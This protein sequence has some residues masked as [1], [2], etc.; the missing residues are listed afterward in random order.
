[1]RIR[2]LAVPVL[3]IWSIAL[4]VGFKQAWQYE[5]TPGASAN[6]P[7]NAKF[8]S[9]PQYRAGAP[10]LLVFAHPQCTCTRATIGNLDTLLAQSPCPL[11]TYVV[12]VRLPGEPAGWEKTDL[13]HSAQAIQGV[14]VLCDQN[15]ILA[16]RF[17]ARTSGQT[18]LYGANG[19]LLF[20]GGITSE[21]GHYGDNTGA[22]EI[23]AE[24]RHP[25]SRPQEAKVFGCAIFETDPP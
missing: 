4:I 16:K 2:W 13:W 3:T 5:S 11:N 25:T 1:M 23:L 20:T 21:R 9:L 24:L 19:N 12:F 18:M 17:G 15:G 8:A 22:D 14:H 6:A 7:V 10:V